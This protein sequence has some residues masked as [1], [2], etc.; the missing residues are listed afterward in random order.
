MAVNATRLRRHWNGDHH[1]LRVGMVVPGGLTV[2]RI[3]RYVYGWRISVNY[4]QGWEYEIFETTWR[5]VRARLAEYRANC[6]YPVKVT[7]G[8]ELNPAYA[9]T[10]VT[11]HGDGV[12]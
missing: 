1:A 8:R 3:N 12:D 6:S 4:G 10:T 2:A 9:S 11:S 5:E 7:R